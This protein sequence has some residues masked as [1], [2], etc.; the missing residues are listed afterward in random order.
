[1]QETQENQT[2][3][4]VS[5]EKKLPINEIVDYFAYIDEICNK[6]M[7]EGVDWMRIPGTPKP[8]LLQPGAQK[9]AFAFKLTDEY[10]TLL[11][12]ENHETE[13]EYEQPIYEWFAGKKRKTGI[14]TKKARGWYFYRVKCRLTSRDT[15]AIINGHLG[16]CSSYDPGKEGAPANTILMM[17]QK[18]AYV[19]AV[20]SATFTSDRFTQD[21]EDN[22]DSI[23][24]DDPASDKQMAFI[25]KLLQSSSVSDDLKTEVDTWAAGEFQSK[26]KASEFIERLQ[27][28]TKKNGKK[29]TGED[30]PAKK[31]E[32]SDLINQIW[33]EEKRVIAAGNMTED[34]V[35]KYRASLAGNA[36]LSKCSAAGL[37]NYLAELKKS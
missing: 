4:I 18:R 35:D 30:A 23:K 16:T 32:N 31:S 33:D 1:M 6:I 14:E 19:A 12:L 37:N 7:K 24:K 25:Q 15:G 28:V 22:P 9:L 34:E 26:A 17:A 10:E 2:R 8:S 29:K 5:I 27:A 13:W 36:D 3:S 20:R 11:C 21:I